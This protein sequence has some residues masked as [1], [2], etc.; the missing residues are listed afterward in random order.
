MNE[1]DERKENRTYIEKCKLCGVTFSEWDGLKGDHIHNF[2][3]VEI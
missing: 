3:V 1:L 2:E